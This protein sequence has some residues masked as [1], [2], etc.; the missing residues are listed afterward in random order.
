VAAAGDAASSSGI[1]YILGILHTLND[2]AKLR[3]SDPR[4][5]VYAVL[6]IT[7]LEDAITVDYLRPVERVYCDLAATLLRTGTDF[8]MLCRVSGA[9]RGGSGLD[10]LPSWVPDPRYFALDAQMDF[11]A[12]L[13][14]A[15]STVSDMRLAV[16]D[17]HVLAAKAVCLDEVNCVASI[18]RQAIKRL[19]LTTPWHQDLRPIQAIAR[20]WREYLSDLPWNDFWR[21]VAMDLGDHMDRRMTE[22]GCQTLHYSLGFAPDSA[23]VVEE[24][25]EEGHHDT[26]PYAALNLREIMISKRPCRTSLGR[27]GNVPSGTQPGDKIFALAGSGLPLVL[28]PAENTIDGLSPC[29]RLI[30][31]CY[32]HGVMDGEAVR[33]AIRAKGGH[34]EP[35]DVFD[36]IYIV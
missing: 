14:Q 27:I 36:E 7:G 35:I 13:F 30:G 16:I 5:A 15:S 34:C 29:F 10:L 20:E 32:L 6:H 25:G 2:F 22:A 11:R 28:R 24:E 18:S 23:S 26:S 9:R 8:R 31:P 1:R 4:D 33:E 3:S 17:E 12:S 19:D 21:I